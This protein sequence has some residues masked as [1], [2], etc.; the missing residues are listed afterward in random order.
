MSSRTLV[1]LIGVAILSMAAATL[2]A[3]PRISQAQAEAGD[4]IKHLHPLDFAHHL[5]ELEHHEFEHFIPDPQ[6]QIDS[7]YPT[8]GPR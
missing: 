7:G 2:V 1:T 5:G 4:K 6:G 3:I 8:I